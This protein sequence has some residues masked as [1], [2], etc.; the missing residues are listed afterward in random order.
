MERIV[1]ALGGNALQM[2]GVPATAAAQLA[3]I[4]KISEQIAAI[5]RQGGEVVVTHGNGPQVGRL[6]LQNEYAAS[7]TPAMPFDVCGAMSQ[8]M[9][10]YHIEQGLNR[11]MRLC[12]LKRE[13]VTVLTQVV[14]DRN[15]PKFQN[16]TK[17]VGPFFSEEEAKRMMAAHGYPMLEDAGRGWRRVVA[18]PNPV[19]IVE[20]GA[21]RC[22]VDHGFVVI[23][24]GG[25]GIPVYRDAD[26]DL[27]GVDAVIDKDLASERLAV[28]LDADVYLMLTAVE[29]VCVNFGRPDQRALDSLTVEE[30][31]EY[32][33]QGQFAAGSM[34]PK[35]KA[36][37]RFVESRKGRRAIVTSPHSAGA[38]FAGNAGTVIG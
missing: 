29:K 6:M 25:G 7:V 27:N 24:V 15:D 10:G 35:I 5:I 31:R 3:I 17:P 32:I 1:L 13:A 9:L 37:L 20:I 4:D 8:G 12:G 33:A 28:D 23:A 19:E 38:A 34:L 22:L 26:G 14:V 21:I 30:A 16:P 36:A 11:A 2:P 18:S